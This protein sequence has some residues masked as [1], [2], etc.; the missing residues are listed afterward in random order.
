MNYGEFGGQ[1]VPQELKSK[2]DAARLKK[3]YPKICEDTKIMITDYLQNL[4]NDKE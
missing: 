3:C 4:F 2:L 1:Y